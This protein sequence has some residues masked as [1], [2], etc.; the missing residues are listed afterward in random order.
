MAIEDL[1][2]SDRNGEGLVSWY[3]IVPFHDPISNIL[4]KVSGNPAG[5]IKVVLKIYLL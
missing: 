1:P 3:A 4:V 5:T 2:L